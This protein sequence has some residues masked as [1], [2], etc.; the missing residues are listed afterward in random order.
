MPSSTRPSSAR[1]TPRGLFG[2]IALLAVHSCSLNSQRMKL[3][4][5][6]LNDVKGSAINPHRPL[7]EP[8]IA[9]NLLPLSEPLPTWPDL[10]LGR[11]YSD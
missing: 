10:P 11:P 9:L 5:R 3:R 1:R 6:S 7:A 8:L 4:F 2:N